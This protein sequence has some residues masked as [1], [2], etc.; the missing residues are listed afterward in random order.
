MINMLP[1]NPDRV[2]FLQRE[3]LMDDQNRTEQLYQEVFSKPFEA[4]VKTVKKME[5]NQDPLL[6]AIP[7]I[8]L[9]HTGLAT[10]A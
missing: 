9:I 1:A 10:R 4:L 5:P 7:V 2:Q 3:R 8:G 6:L